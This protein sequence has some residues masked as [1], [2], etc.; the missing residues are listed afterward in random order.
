MNPELRLL[1]GRSDRRLQMAVTDAS[2]VDQRV[3][4]G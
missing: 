3:K 4:S 2:W 1:S